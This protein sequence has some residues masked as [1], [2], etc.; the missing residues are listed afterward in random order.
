GGQG[1][2]DYTVFPSVAGTYDMAGQVLT[3]IKAVVLTLVLSG[4]VSAVLFY[5]LKA[6]TGLRPSKEVETEGLDINEHGERAY[7]Y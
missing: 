2:V 1:W 6:T 3:Q 5:G 7:N 4:G